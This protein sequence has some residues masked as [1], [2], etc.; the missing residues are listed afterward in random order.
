MKNQICIMLLAI[1]LFAYTDLCQIIKF[2]H[3]ISHYREHCAQNGAMGFVGFLEMHYGAH[4]HAKTNPD[5]E[6]MQ[7]PFKALSFHIAIQALAV[8][9]FSVSPLDAAGQ[10]HH[11]TFGYYDHFIPDPLTGSLFRPPIFMM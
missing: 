8:P 11:F 4:P 10:V 6:D 9:G 3:L 7:L 1:H 5:K 2:P